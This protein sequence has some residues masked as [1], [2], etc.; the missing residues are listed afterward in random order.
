MF[1][2]ATLSNWLGQ[3]LG[4]LLGNTTPE[5]HT[6]V[7]QA[8]GSKAWPWLRP[9]NP[10]LTA[11]GGPLISILEGH[12]Y[13]VKAVAVT[14]DGRRAVS[15]SV[16]QTLRLWDLENGNEIATFTGEGKMHCC[17]SAPDGWTIVADD[18]L[19]RVHLPAPR[20]SGRNKASDWRYKDPATASRASTYQ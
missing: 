14:P 16:D 8:A 10:N 7:N 3:L 6:L 1:W 18:A 9:L 13:S 2:L 11:P 12:T 19:G 5:I 17:A 15:G 4:R 20:R